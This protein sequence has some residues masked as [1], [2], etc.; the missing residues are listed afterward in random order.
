M[1]LRSLVNEVLEARKGCVAEK[2][3][4]ILVERLLSSVAIEES[5][6]VLNESLKLDINDLLPFDAKKLLFEKIILLERDEIIMKQFAW[7]LQLNGGP[8]WDDL[9]QDLLSQ[10]ESL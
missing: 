9:A 3:W 8:D 6:F 7:W 5:L 10:A 2:Q 4:L 1:G